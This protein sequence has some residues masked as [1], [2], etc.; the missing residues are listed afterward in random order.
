MSGN[1][2]YQELACRCYQQPT[3]RLATGA[4]R[5]SSISNGVGPLAN[6][7]P[8]AIESITFADEIQSLFRGAAFFASSSFNCSR[9]KLCLHE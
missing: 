1:A 4:I 2:T 3:K 5:L 9:L 7:P 8:R 6:R